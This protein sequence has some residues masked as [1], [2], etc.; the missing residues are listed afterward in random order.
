[1]LRSRLTHEAVLI[2]GRAVGRPAEL[3][4]LPIVGRVR[5]VPRD[6]VPL[7]SFRVKVRVYRLRAGF[8]FG[9]RAR[10]R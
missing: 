2:G 6:G 1:M 5:A 3:L 9:A 7:V 4:H 10:A 8:G